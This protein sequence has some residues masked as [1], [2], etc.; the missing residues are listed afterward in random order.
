MQHVYLC[1]VSPD[2]FVADNR[3]RL[4]AAGQQKKAKEDG[5]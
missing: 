4:Q 2:N 5:C 1:R 3:L